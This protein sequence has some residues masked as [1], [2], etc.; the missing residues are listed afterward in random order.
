M[1]RQIT[2][3][4]VMAVVCAVAGGAAF[5]DATIADDQTEG[6][7]QISGTVVFS[8]PKWDAD[9]D[10]AVYAPSQYPGDHADKDTHYIYAYQLFNDTE[11]DVTMSSL[12]IGLDSG[13]GVANVWYDDTYG[14]SGGDIPYVSWFLPLYDPNP[15]SVQWVGSWV[16]G[17]HSTVLLFSSPYTYTWDSA[18]VVN[19]GEGETLSLPSPLPEP[20]TMILLC[21]GAVPILLRYRRKVSA[22]V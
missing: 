6:Y 18:T 1:G 4:A 11:S 20:A 7:A 14:V 2:R 10:Y 17:N 13:A 15:T 21:G 3:F 5:A 9:V 19:G 8:A 22:E 12:S 16:P